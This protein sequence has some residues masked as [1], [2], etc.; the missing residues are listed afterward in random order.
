MTDPRT[1]E[2]I[3]ANKDKYR[4]EDLKQTLLKSGVSPADVEEAVRLAAPLPQQPGP[5]QAA[6]PPGNVVG[7]LEGALAAAK[8]E[9]F[10]AQV[11]ATR[12]LKTV[13]SGFL[14]LG[15]LTLPISILSGM[16]L[17][18][19]WVVIQALPLI[20]F[21]LAWGFLAVTSWLM[22]ANDILLL[23]GYVR[24]LMQF[25]RDHLRDIDD[26]ISMIRRLWVF[27]MALTCTLPA[28]PLLFAQDI[29][30]ALTFANYSAILGMV[31]GVGLFFFFMRSYTRTA[32]AELPRMIEGAG[33]DAP[34]GKYPA[35]KPAGLACLAFV[36]GLFALGYRFPDV[37][38]RFA[39]LPAQHL[40]QGSFYLVN[41]EFPKAILEFDQA[42]EMSPGLAGAYVSRGAA[43]LLTGQFDPALADMDKGIEL[44]SREA[45]TYAARGNVHVNK[46][47]FDKAL[48]DYDKAIG[49][50]LPTNAIAA[51]V[52][53]NRGTAYLMKG[54]Y[55]QAIADL[56]K[57]LELG[58][59]DPVIYATRANAHLGKGDQDKALADLDKALELWIERTP[60]AAPVYTNRGSIYFMKGL[61]DKAIADLDKA[62]AL[63]GGKEPNAFAV[64]A[65]AHFAKGNLDQAVADYDQAIG[66]G[67]RIVPVFINRGR[68]YLVKGEYAPAISDFDQVIAASP[69]EIQVYHLRGNAKMLTGALRE[70]L[71]DFQAEVTLDPNATGGYC[72]AG[73][74]YF[75]NKDYRS[76]QAS[77]MKSLAVK[78]TAEA[79]AGLAIALLRQGKKAQALKAFQKAVKLEPAFAQGAEAALA[80]TSNIYTKRQSEALNALAGLHSK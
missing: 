69:Q 43:Y 45:L 80:K 24:F 21:K 46:G 35:W 60:F 17:R 56:D 47:N 12:R 38:G 14:V 61:N 51:P 62:V 3:R 15:I 32:Q 11:P 53:A 49:M 19:K 41:K 33:E 55:D 29:S 25:R 66:L 75:E 36:A 10:L 30:S 72:G 58:S 68:A 59:S 57:A 40:D 39:F 52:Y 6:S 42:I 1:V 74:V 16:S 7:K 64:R 26:T 20:R 28:L 4:L 2:Y 50:G 65:N 76:C 34:R 79:Q 67:L 13:V 8:K 48:A 5:G 31:A 78:E 9:K 73:L 77:M 37:T 27:K 44:G 18:V 70:A 23:Y 54:Q 63:G 71:A 22:A